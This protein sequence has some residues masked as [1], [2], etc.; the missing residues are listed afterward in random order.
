MEIKHLILIP[1]V[2]N[3]HFCQN[4]EIEHYSIWPTRCIK[5]R[6]I[7][8]LRYLVRIERL[9]DVD[10]HHSNCGSNFIQENNEYKIKRMSTEMLN[11][12]NTFLST[13]AVRKK[14][15]KGN[16]VIQSYLF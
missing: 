13:P 8:Q 12:V 3:T 16:T 11:Q 5:G 10:V 7:L 2:H 15:Y 9:K 4:M 14:R 6:S 1:T